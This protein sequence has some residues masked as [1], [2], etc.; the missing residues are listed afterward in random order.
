MKK[1]FEEE[2][3][4]LLEKLRQNQD[5]QTKEQSPQQ[6][7]KRQ[8]TTP[9]TSCSAATS[10]PTTVTVPETVSTTSVRALF[11][12]TSSAPTFSD[13]LSTTATLNTST[14]ST[15]E[16]HTTSQY[17]DLSHAEKAPS[18][19]VSTTTGHLA[20]KSV[21]PSSNVATVGRV[22]RPTET[23][24]R[25]YLEYFTVS[26]D[27]SPVKLST[28]VSTKR[29]RQLVPLTMTTSPNYKAQTTLVPSSYRSTTP[30]PKPVKIVSISTGLPFRP[31]RPALTHT[32]TSSSTVRTSTPKTSASLPPDSRAVVSGVESD[33]GELESN[34]PQM[35]WSDISFTDSEDNATSDPGEPQFPPLFRGRLQSARRGRP[36][37]RTPPRYCTD[38]YS[39]RRDYVKYESLR[40]EHCSKSR[41]SVKLDPLTAMPPRRYIQ[42]RPERVARPRSIKEREATTP[43]PD[44]S[45][46]PSLL[47]RPKRRCVRD[48]IVD[49]PSPSNTLPS[50]NEDDSDDGSCVITQVE[51]PV[52]TDD[53]DSS[54]NLDNNE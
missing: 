6:P 36:A 44:R 38:S 5:K 7:Q 35:H 10:V 11:V 54:E 17:A 34:Q 32:T 2:K 53:F 51:S 46:S 19:T 50:E 20:P 52:D 42:P 48:P 24:F 1:Q 30:K 28:P 25:S 9:T 15:V 29:R 49:P 21:A 40:L 39:Y 37:S 4:A 18:S 14:A 13:T 33:N 23:I 3:N 47:E 45:P 41:W 22:A 26:S 31:V 16:G 8:E 27:G 43:S 12:P